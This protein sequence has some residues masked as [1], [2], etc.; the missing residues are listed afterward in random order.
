MG[1]TTIHYKRFIVFLNQISTINSNMYLLVGKGSSMSTK[2]VALLVVSIFFGIDNFGKGSSGGR[3][4]GGGRGASS[5]SG[6]RNRAAPAT[7]PSSVRPTQPA[8][9]FPTSKP[10]T[11]HHIVHHH[12]SSTPQQSGF[13]NTFAGSA[14]GSYFGNRMAQTYNN[15]SSA[16]S[17]SSS[18]PVSSGVN[19]QENL[20]NDV[21]N[22]EEAND[23]ALLQKPENGSSNTLLYVAAG[24]FGVAGA[25]YAWNAWV[26]NNATKLMQSSMTRAI[27]VYRP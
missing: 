8:P 4:S 24:L 7:R 13:F 14:I 12:A 16:S 1:A 9:R 6:G 10:V 15:S 2:K 25:R 18:Y 11:E 19:S 5:F 17:Q 22:N 21:K 3:S 23:H 27:R 26:R 20:E